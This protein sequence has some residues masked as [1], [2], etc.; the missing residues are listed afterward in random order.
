MEP[1]DLD[2]SFTMGELVSRGEALEIELAWRSASACTYAKSHA[3]LLLHGQVGLEQSIFSC[4]TCAAAAGGKPIGV[5]EV[6]MLKCHGDHEVAEVGTRRVFR[7]DCATTRAPDGTPCCAQPP[8]MPASGLPES[9][10]AYGQNFA[11]R[12]C[13]CQSAYDEERD[14]MLQCVACCEWYHDVHIRGCMPPKAGCDTLIC[15]SCVSRRPF[16][17]SFGRFTPG[18]CALPQS[19]TVAPAAAAGTGSPTPGA[20]GAA[21][22][23]PVAETD[24]TGASGPAGFI[25]QPWATCLTCTGGLDDGRG[26]CLACA[27]A[28]HAGHVLDATRITFFAC[29]CEDLLLP[30]AAACKCK[31]AEALAAEAAAPAANTPAPAAEPPLLPALTGLGEGRQGISGKRALADPPHGTSVK[32]A[33]LDDAY[34]VSTSIPVAPPRCYFSA[35]SPGVPPAET[36]AYAAG[37]AIFLDDLGYLVDSLCACGACMRVYSDAKLLSWFVPGHDAAGG[38]GYVVDPEYSEAIRN[39]GGLSLLLS[40][41]RPADGEA[42]AGAGAGAGSGGG[43]SSGPPGYLPL[44]DRAMSELLQLP[45]AVSVP[46]LRGVRE[47]SAAL[48]DFLHE[49]QAANPGAIVRKADVERFVERFRDQQQVARER[50]DAG[51][52]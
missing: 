36:T 7:C 24:V 20:G 30:S 5:C 25:L 42:P 41:P 29:D 1:F 18:R 6:C 51:I 48:V 23:S 32:R 35:I 10:N 8:G 16:L 37:A 43:A 15:A 12:F 2:A 19:A 4:L 28:C 21:A 27:A 40:G 13:S 44:A 3:L 49:H 50:A 22:T 9:P 38:A 26:V 45:T 17:R 11:D 33:R 14:T 31:E 46:V 47:M 39:A 34:A 52:I